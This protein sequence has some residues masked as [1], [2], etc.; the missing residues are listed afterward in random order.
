V[1]HEPAPGRR[2]VDCTRPPT[3]RDPD[4]VTTRNSFENPK[5]VS[6]RLARQSRRASA[7]LR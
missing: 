2:R 3:R 4:P 1:E 5:A 6:E 7:H